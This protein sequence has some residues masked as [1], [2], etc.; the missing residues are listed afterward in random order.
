MFVWFTLKDTSGNPWQ[1]GLYGKSGAKK[2]SYAAFSSVA[3]LVDGDGTTNVKAGRTPSVKVY[4]PGLAYY[5]PTGQTLT[6]TYSVKNG[7]RSVSVSSPSASA[8][9]GLDQSVSFKPAFSPAKGKSYTV[10][11]QIRDPGGHTVSRTVQ[12]NAT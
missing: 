3:R 4:V 2:P 6:L 12:L 9:L 5:T 1:S 10:T 7:T 8:R 11:A